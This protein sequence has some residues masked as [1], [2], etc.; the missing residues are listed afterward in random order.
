MTGGPLSSSYWRKRAQQA[1]AEAAKELDPGAKSTMETI[2]RLYDE[3]AD[4]AALRE[5]GIQPDEQ[6]D[7]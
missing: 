7:A 6:G 4:R 1:R 2:A 5:R 3:L